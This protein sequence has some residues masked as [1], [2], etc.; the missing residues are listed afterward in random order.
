QWTASGRTFKRW[1]AHE[2]RFRQSESAIRNVAGPVYRLVSR[3]RLSAKAGSRN[4]GGSRYRRVSKSTSAKRGTA[5]KTLKAE[6]C[7]I[8]AR[9]STASES[10]ELDRYFSAFNFFSNFSTLGLITTWQ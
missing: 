5:E 6:R 4:Q 10:P 1:H 7:E 3:F 8:V 9:F 2:R